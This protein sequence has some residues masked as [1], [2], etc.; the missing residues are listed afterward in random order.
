MAQLVAPALIALGLFIFV[1]AT[2][3]VLR[4]NKTY[5]AQTDVPQQQAPPTATE[6]TVA[7]PLETHVAQIGHKTIVTE[8]LQTL[9]PMEMP[10]LPKESEELSAAWWREQLQELTRDVQNL[11]QQARIVE[12][13]VAI[14][15]TIAS[16]MTELEDLRHGYIPPEEERLSAQQISFNATWQ[17][18]E[19]LRPTEKRPVVRKYTI[20]AM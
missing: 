2:F 17:R 18:M 19:L 6:H 20:K 1:S 16:C 4:E 12:R 11:H 7:A 8:K 14:L 3:L 10:S 9:S 13:R 5:T 15:T